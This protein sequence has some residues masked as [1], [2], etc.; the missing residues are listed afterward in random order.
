[1]VIGSR[2]ITRGTSEPLEYLNAAAFLFL[3]VILRVAFFAYFN[4][5]FSSTFTFC[6]HQLHHGRCC[7]AEPM[8]VFVDK[9]FVET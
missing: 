8:N 6:Q 4:N 3:D 5:S 2:L 7:T 1:M 9:S